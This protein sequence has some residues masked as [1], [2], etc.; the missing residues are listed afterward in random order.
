ML[1]RVFTLQFNTLLAGFDDGPLR[2]FIKDKEVLSIRD[3]FFI[4]NDIA[5][6]AL[7]VTYLPTRAEAATHVA[8]SDGRKKESWRELVKPEDIPL[9]NTLRDWR[10]ERCKKD[11]LPPYVICTMCDCFAFGFR[12]V[13]TVDFR[14]V[15]DGLQHVVQSSSCVASAT[16]EIRDEPIDFNRRYATRA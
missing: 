10:A 9:F 13:G 3:H 1:V 2:D 8:D 12:P 11:G 5:Y 16:I 6:L 15:I 14:Q 4:K 7:I